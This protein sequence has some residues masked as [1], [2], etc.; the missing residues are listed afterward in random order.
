MRLGAFIAPP[1]DVDAIQMTVADL[2]RQ[3]RAGVL[4]VSARFDR[5]A[6]EFDIRRTAAVFSDVLTQAFGPRVS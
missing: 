4:S 3:W 6:A 2:L 1:D 5:V